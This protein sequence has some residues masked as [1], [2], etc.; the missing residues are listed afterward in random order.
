M[1]S[2]PSQR[3]CVAQI[4]YSL[5]LL[6]ISSFKADFPCWVEGSNWRETKKCR[7][8]WSWK[9][10]LDFKNTNI[11]N[12][13]VLIKLIIK[14]WRQHFSR[15]IFSI[16]S[17]LNCYVLFFVITHNHNLNLLKTLNFIWIV[18]AT[19]IVVVVELASNSFWRSVTNFYCF[20]KLN[21]SLCI[22]TTTLQNGR[23]DKKTA[24]LR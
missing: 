17:F 15:H 2:P 21:M 22:S 11:T 20:H 3:T 24:S 1:N 12:F 10:F 7:I 5:C 4:I 19:T 23:G 14:V 9:T 16:W 8:C 13:M 18:Y 6:R